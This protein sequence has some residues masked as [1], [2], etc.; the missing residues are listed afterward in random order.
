ML[1]EDEKLF[2]VEFKAV[3]DVK[4]TLGL[5]GKALGGDGFAWGFV[6]GVLVTQGAH[7]HLSGLH[8]A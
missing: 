8:D 1:I 6:L 3:V 7:I 5:E 2:V 4:N